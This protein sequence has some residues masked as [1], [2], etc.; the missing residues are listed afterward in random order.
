MV[1]DMVYI[2]VYSEEMNQ[3][4]SLFNWDKKISQSECLNIF[5]EEG[6]QTRLYQTRY[7]QSKVKTWKIA[8]W[9]SSLENR[10]NIEVY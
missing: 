6:L 10:V 8:S 7:L 4:Q 5:I 9:R 1:S 2:S 3:R